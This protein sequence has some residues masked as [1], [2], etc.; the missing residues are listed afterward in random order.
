MVNVLVAML[1]VA[2]IFPYFYTLFYPLFCIFP[3]LLGLLGWLERDEL[4]WPGAVATFVA[5]GMLLHWLLAF[6]WR[7]GIIS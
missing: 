5:G 2:G 4:K 1:H 3:L 7:A 6:L